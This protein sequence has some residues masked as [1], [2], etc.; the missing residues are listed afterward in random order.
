MDNVICV[1]IRSSLISIKN[2]S[3]EEDFQDIPQIA[4][5]AL[6]IRKKVIAYGKEANFPYGKPPGTIVLKAELR[7][8]DE[9]LSDLAREAQDDSVGDDQL[10]HAKIGPATADLHAQWRGSV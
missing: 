9:A 5:Q 4:V 10:A 2:L 1:Q 8:F 7:S 6:G 3:N